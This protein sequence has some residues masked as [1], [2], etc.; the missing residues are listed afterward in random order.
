M[1][2]YKHTH[3]EWLP[4][5]RNENG[6]AAACDAELEDGTFCNLPAPICVGGTEYYCTN[7]ADKEESF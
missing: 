2:K 5:P 6:V 3:Y 1:T 4:L 7:H